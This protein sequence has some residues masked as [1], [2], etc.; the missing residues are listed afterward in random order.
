MEAEQIYSFTGATWTEIDVKSTDHLQRLG[1]INGCDVWDWWVVA[2]AKHYFIASDCESDRMT[3]G[4]CAL[5]NV[6]GDKFKTEVA[7]IYIFTTLR[8]LLK[9]PIQDLK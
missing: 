1:L 7:C 2:L 5:R 6:S 3:C 4:M 8:I 9:T